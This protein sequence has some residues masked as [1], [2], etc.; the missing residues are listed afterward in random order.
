MPGV[1][2]ITRGAAAAAPQRGAQH[3]ASTTVTVL[4]DGLALHPMWLRE[5]CTAADTHGGSNNVEKTESGFSNV[6]VQAGTM[7]PLWQPHEFR[8]NIAITQ[9]DTYDVSGSAW[10]ACTFSDGHRSLFAVDNLLREVVAFRK[11][12]IQVRDL[13]APAPRVVQSTTHEPERFSFGA[14]FPSGDIEHGASDPQTV[15]EVL[16]TLMREGHVILEGVPS[17]SGNVVKVGQAFVGMR[18]RPTNW[19]D[20]FNVEN[21]FDASN[22]GL[23]DLAYTAE[24]LP[25][26]VDNPYRD[27]SPQFQIL[28]TLANESEGGNSTAVDGFAVALELRESHP[29]YFELLTQVGVRWENDCGGAQAANVSFKPHIVLD[30]GDGSVQQVYYSSKSGGYAPA[31]SDL[32]VMDK[33]YAARRLFA[34]MLNDPARRV[35]FRLKTGDVWLFNN[36]RMLHGRTAYSPTGRRHLQGCYVDLDGIQYGFYN[37]KHRLAQL[38]K[39]TTQMSAGGAASPTQMRIDGAAEKVVPI[40]GSHVKLLP[41][42]TPPLERRSTKS[43]SRGGS[44]ATFDEGGEVTPTL[45]ALTTASSKETAL[46]A[47]GAAQGGGGGVGREPEVGRAE[48]TSAW[49]SAEGKAK[50][51]AGLSEAARAQVGDLDVLACKPTVKALWD[52]DEV[53]HEVAGA[54]YT[55]Q[56]AE[57]FFYSEV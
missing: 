34:S 26:H 11:Q 15:H 19:G 46:Q 10:L 44:G 43:R 41:A 49:M 9:A 31:L 5:R 12:G 52:L 24:A 3:T 53:D 27:P 28:H 45:T 29:E 22:G 20:F 18:V 57:S 17:V 16:E 4:L 7:Q 37:A 39:M 8:A 25:P 33:F 13:N 50:V 23:A 14:V 35:E 6:S 47:G 1:I 30:P 56:F 48:G 55:S 36:L 51:R 38:L 21:K 40:G 2:S 42:G 54:L 32:T